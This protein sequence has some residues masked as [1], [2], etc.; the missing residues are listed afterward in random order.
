MYFR[1]H[2][3]A[4]SSIIQNGGLTFGLVFPLLLVARHARGC[5]GFFLFL[6]TA[7]LFFYGL[8]LVLQLCFIHLQYHTQHGQGWPGFWK[9]EAFIFLIPLRPFKAPMGNRNGATVGLIA[10]TWAFFVAR[11]FAL[12]PMSYNKPINHNWFITV[13]RTSLHICQYHLSESPDSI[14]RWVWG[15]APAFLKA[16]G[17]PFLRTRPFCFFQF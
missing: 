3:T 10:A 7:P 2:R 17:F 9:R 1:S 12:S 11:F 8:W 4:P 14:D 15:R 5:P 16:D 13:T 6:E